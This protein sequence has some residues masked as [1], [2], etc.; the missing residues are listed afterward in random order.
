MP[1]EQLGVE[2]GALSVGFDDQ[3]D[4]LRREAIGHHAVGFV[5]RPE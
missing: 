3:G 4:R 2:P 1:G 5:D